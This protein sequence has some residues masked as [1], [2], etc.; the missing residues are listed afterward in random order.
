MTN[1][2]IALAA[3]IALCSSG[4]FTPFYFGDKP[5]RAALKQQKGSFLSNK[6]KA[7]KKRNKK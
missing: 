7:I 4:G 1:P 3:V 2:K 5:T 6:R